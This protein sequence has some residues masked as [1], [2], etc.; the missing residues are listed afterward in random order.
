MAFSV[1]IHLHT[2][3]LN[4]SPGKPSIHP[5]ADPTGSKAKDIG[6]VDRRD[7]IRFEI[8]HNIGGLFR[9][10]SVPLP[11]MQMEKVL[12]F[13]DKHSFV[14]A[15]KKEFALFKR[16]KTVQALCKS[17][18][19]RFEIGFIRNDFVQT[20]PDFVLDGIVDIMIA[21]PQLVHNVPQKHSA[22]SKEQHAKLNVSLYS[23]DTLRERDK[24]KRNKDMSIFNFLA[25]LGAMLYLFSSFI[26]SSLLIALAFVFICVA[27]ATKAVLNMLNKQS[28]FYEKKENLDSIVNT[29]QHEAFMAGKSKPF[30]HI[31]KYLKHPFFFM[32]GLRQVDTPKPKI[33]TVE[34]KREKCLQAV[35]KRNRVILHLHKEPALTQANKP[36]SSEVASL[37]ANDSGKKP[38][39]SDKV[40]RKNPKRTCRK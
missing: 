21:N 13:K 16:D 38:A 22:M 7:N 11:M 23:L 34:D 5:M 9:D 25:G 4:G 1:K 10:P 19:L 12:H 33:M 36:Q 35:L 3:Y 39:V 29:P 31:F 2:F 24:V 30:Y 18:N 6:R 8:N 14:D 37:A 32:V 20:L 26:P 15:F 27:V 40:N 17:P 28:E